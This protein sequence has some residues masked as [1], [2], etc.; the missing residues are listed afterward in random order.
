MMVH[1]SGRVA[2]AAQMLVERD[3]ARVEKSAG[4]EMR[5]QMHQTQAACQLADCGCLCRE[6]VWRDLALRKGLVEHSFV[7]DQFRAERFSSRVH[8]IENRLN[9]LPLRRGELK[10]PGERQ[11][12]NRSR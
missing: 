5:S 4:F 11:H 3:L 7:F 1:R 2:V 9:L 8:P 6:A 12:M 10:F